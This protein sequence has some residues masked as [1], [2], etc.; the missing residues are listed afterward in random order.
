MAD[1]QKPQ[2]KRFNVELPNDLNATYAN[3]AIISH[4][5]TELIID[6]AQLLPGM[7]KARVQGR[8]LLTPMNAKMLYQALGQNL[9]KY[10]RRFGK[11]QPIGQQSGFF[12]PKTGTLGGL[13]WTVGGDED[14]DNDQGEDE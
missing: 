6:F 5:P 11:I 13:Q 3:F 10:E 4:S 2:G 7:P 1:P 8:I 12:D 9:V 14:D